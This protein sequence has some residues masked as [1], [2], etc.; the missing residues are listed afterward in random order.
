M[1]LRSMPGPQRT[2]GATGGAPD[3]AVG[4]AP[5]G[6]EASVIAVAT[7]VAVAGGWGACCWRRS[8]RPPCLGGCLGPGWARACPAGAAAGRFTYGAMA[9]RL[10]RSCCSSCVL[11]L[12]SATSTPRMPLMRVGTMLSTLPK[13]VLLLLLTPI[14]W[15]LAP[16]SLS[17]GRWCCRPAMNCCARLRLG[18]SPS[19]VCASAMARLAA[20]SWPFLSTGPLL[21]VVPMLPSRRPTW[22]VRWALKVMAL[23]A[24][25]ESRMGWPVAASHAAT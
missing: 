3:G 23:P 22:L 4:P 9:S 13:G 2:G 18:C 19:V 10:S 7:T 25:A 15:S 1:L 6:A 5:G 20:C 11:V 16:D 8:G 21:L 14:L 12:A 24:A 17:W